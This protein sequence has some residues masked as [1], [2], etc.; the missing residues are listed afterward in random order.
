MIESLA[1]TREVPAGTPLVSATHNMM[2]GGMCVGTHSSNGAWHALPRTSIEARDNLMPRRMRWPRCGHQRHSAQ[3]AHHPNQRMSH[4]CRILPESEDAAQAAADSTLR[5]DD[6]IRQ[7]AI[8][9]PQTRW[10]AT[11]LSWQPCHMVSRRPCHGT[12][13]ACRV[14][15]WQAPLTKF[16]RCSHGILVALHGTAHCLMSSVHASQ[17]CKTC[18]Q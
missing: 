16:P 12:G 17:R 2:G 10:P 4:G 15:L 9:L 1:N 6:G 7:D 3:H 11:F 8:I 14:G 18:F 5:P 13:A